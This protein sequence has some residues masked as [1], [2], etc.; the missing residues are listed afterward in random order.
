MFA[1]GSP[2]SFFDYINPDTPLEKLEEYTS[3]INDDYV[4]VGHTHKP[5]ILKTPNVTI[6]NPEHSAAER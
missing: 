4:I 3:G 2:A 1:H 6:L 5:A